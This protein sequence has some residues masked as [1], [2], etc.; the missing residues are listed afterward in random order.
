M[1]RDFFNYECQSS[2]AGF[3]QFAAGNSSAEAVRESFSGLSDSIKNALFQ[4]VWRETGT[5]ATFDRQWGESHAFDDMQIFYRAL[6]KFV[7]RSF[8]GLTRDEKNV[9]YGHVCQLAQ[10]E[11]QTK[12]VDFSDPGWGKDHAFDN[13]LRLIDAMMLLSLSSREPAR[14]VT[15]PDND[16]PDWELL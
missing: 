10:R 5:S 4:C 2:F 12:A 1:I 16:F 14:S 9:V 6:E 7:L 11:T 3:Y 13:V 15:E 8:Q